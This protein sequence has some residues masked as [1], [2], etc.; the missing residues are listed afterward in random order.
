MTSVFYRP[1]VQQ[2][3]FEFSV[4]NTVLPDCTQYIVLESGALYFSIITAPSSPKL[5]SWKDSTL[6]CCRSCRA[7][8]WTVYV[9]DISGPAM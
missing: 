5:Q 2:T 4:L 6:N 8:S 3:V 1:Q 7:L 9:I